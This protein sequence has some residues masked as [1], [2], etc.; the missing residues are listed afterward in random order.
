MGVSSKVNRLLQNWFSPGSEDL[1]PNGEWDIKSLTS[2]LKKF[3]GNLPEPLLTYQLHS[4]FI[5]AVKAPEKTKA[6]KV[7]V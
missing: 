5:N 3:F 7:E 6:A 2:A 4:K 1:S